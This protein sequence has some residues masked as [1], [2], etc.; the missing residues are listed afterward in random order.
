MAEQLFHRMTRVD[1]PNDVG[2]HLTWFT[3]HLDER[4]GHHMLSIDGEPYNIP[5]NSAS[6]L[7]PSA[8]TGI[9]AYQQ[10]FYTATLLPIF[11]AAI[12]NGTGTQDA[13][14]KFLHCAP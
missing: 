9:P 7:Q 3:K 8:Q 13:D 10:H 4:T 6:A 5:L 1:E 11:P 14:E 12:H 2:T